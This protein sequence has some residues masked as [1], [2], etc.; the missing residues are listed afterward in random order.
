MKKILSKIFKILIIIFFLFIGF[1][2]GLLF[3]SQLSRG[4][5]GIARLFELIGSLFLAY[6]LV[7]IIHEGGHLVFGLLTGYK[8][9]SFRIWSFMMIKQNGKMRFRRFSLAGTG[10]QC[11]MIPPEKGDTKASVILY[12]LGGVIFNFILTVLCLLIYFLIPE[13]YFLSTTLWYTAILSVFTM[14]SNGIPFNV[15]GIAN[16]GMNARHLSKNPDAAESFRKQLLVNAS[17]TEGARISEMPEEWF[18][19]PEGADMKNVHCASLAVFAVQRILDSGDIVAAERAITEL[20]DSDYNVIGLY[21]NL[22]TCD[23]IYCR[24]SIDPTADVT[25]L[26]TP[27]LKKLMQS[28]KNYPSIIRTQYVIALLVDK[29]QVAAE[30]IMAGFDKQTAKFPYP[31]EVACEKAA[32]LEI[33]EKSKNAI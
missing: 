13:T 26:I 17:Q 29:D 8:F 28:M 2:V 7:I 10:G 15:G 32:M 30:K 23:L 19:L 16:D 20:L 24:L 3:A 9:S 1:C 31:Q 18:T 6:N 25:D 22:L 4:S 12:N 21:R 27:E 33:L 14:I 11:L 5:D